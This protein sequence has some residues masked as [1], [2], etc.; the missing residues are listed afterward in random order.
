MY[1]YSLENLETVN[2]VNTNERCTI[3]DTCS[4][5]QGDCDN[6]LQCQDGLVC[7]INNC[8]KDFGSSWNWYDDCCTGKLYLRLAS[9]IHG[10][11]QN[12]YKI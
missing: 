1:H 4:N 10:I 3:L 9:S 7:G 11:N 8:Q 6:D 5:G 2:T 12:K